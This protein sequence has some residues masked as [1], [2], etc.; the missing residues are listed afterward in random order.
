MLDALDTHEYGTLERAIEKW[1][2]RHQEDKCLEEMSELSKEILKNRD[3][4]SSKEKIAEEA[5]D[6]YI[7]LLQLMI[8]HDCNKEFNKHFMEKMNRLDFRIGDNQDDN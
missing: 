4:L 2:P 3:G 5:A 6:L 7:T 1:G 8:I